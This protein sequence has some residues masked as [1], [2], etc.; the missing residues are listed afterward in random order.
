MKVT[1]FR[2]E[3]MRE[4]P[5]KIETTSNEIINGAYEKIG[6]YYF[7][8]QEIK[9]EADEL[10]NQETLFELERSTYKELKDCKKDLES[11]KKMWDLIALID[12]QFDSWRNTL[13]DKIDTDLLSTLIKDMK[14]KQCQPGAP[15]NKEIKSYRAFTALTERVKNMSTILPLISSLHSPYMQ[16]R[17]WNRLA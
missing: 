10:K 12:L 13:W 9:N 11:L 15:Q 7:K 3:F 6:E 16:D 4:L 1:K 5:F 17:H 14:D 8:L 2:Q